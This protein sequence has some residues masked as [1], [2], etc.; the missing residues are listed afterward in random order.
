MVSLERACQDL[1]YI[2]KKDFFS[3]INYL[4]KW[5]SLSI[6]NNTWLF[7][8]FIASKFPKNFE[9]GK[10]STNRNQEKALKNDTIFE[11]LLQELH[12]VKASLF[13]VMT[14]KHTNNAKQLVL[15]Y[16]LTRRIIVWWWCRLCRRKNRVFAK[17]RKHFLF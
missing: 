4:Y 9:A 5:I 14:N 2:S 15:F 16:I 1:N 8:K 17:S 11:I 7:H 6:C 3:S 12:H 13:W 10:F